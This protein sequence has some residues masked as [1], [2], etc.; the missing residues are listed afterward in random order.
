MKR[1]LECSGNGIRYRFNVGIA[2]RGRLTG[3][4]TPVTDVKCPSRPP[5]PNEKSRSRRT[6]DKR[7]TITRK[8]NSDSTNQSPQ[9]CPFNTDRQMPVLPWLE[10]LN[11][12]SRFLF[13]HFSW[14]IASGMVILDG[15]NNG[16]RNVLLPFALHDSLAQDA[17]ISVAAYH[18][19]QSNPE[20]QCRAA[21]GRRR[22]LERLKCQVSLAPD[23]SPLFTAST[24]VTLLVL[25]VGEVTIAGDHYPYLLRM[26]ASLQAHGIVDGNMELIEFLQ[27]QT[28]LMSALAIPFTA[29]SSDTT[30]RVLET[31][32]MNEKEL[33]LQAA[34]S[35]PQRE[36]VTAV[37]RAFSLAFHIYADSSGS[38]RSGNAAMLQQLRE[39]VAPLPP[40]TAG[41]NSLIWVY[42]VGAAGCDTEEQRLFF[43]GRLR[44][45]YSNTGW[46]SAG[47]GL[48][49][50]A[51]MRAMKRTGPWTRTLLKVS[52]TIVI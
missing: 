20:L 9:Q 25:L 38:M 35:H 27:S 10:P 15:A 42:F 48:S 5:S 24:W 40:D 13:N 3:L 19:A 36:I 31:A 17:V 29:A 22:I 39:T 23:E 47:A 45:I 50:L 46:M 16:Y 2:S 37:S 12:H 52:T 4:S 49:M 28:A 18:L 43:A 41:G 30:Q 14:N 8:A 26:M 44:E 33:Y 6:A 1:G 11:A 51:Q 7:A 21:D 32:L 34:A